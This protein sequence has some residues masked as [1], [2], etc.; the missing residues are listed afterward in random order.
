MFGYRSAQMLRKS[1]RSPVPQTEPV[2]ILVVGA[3]NVGKSGV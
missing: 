2:N 1:S 3:R